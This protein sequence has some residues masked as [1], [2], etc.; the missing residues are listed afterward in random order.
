MV[1]VGAGS[2]PLDGGHHNCVRL[3]GKRDLERVRSPRWKAWNTST[4]RPAS[5]IP[6]LDRNSTAPPFGNPKSLAKEAFA[7]RASMLRRPVPA[8]R[9]ADP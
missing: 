6:T 4:G 5:F 1:D 8:A 7:V 9:R 2:T 3:L